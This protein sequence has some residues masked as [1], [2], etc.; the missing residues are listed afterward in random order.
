MIRNYPALQ[1]EIRSAVLPNGL[2]VYYIPKPDF[3]KTFAM[4]AADFG[5]VDCCFTLDGEQH[6]VT[7][8]VAHFLEHKMFEEEDGNALQKFTM[9]GAQPNA[10][11]SHTMT[12]YHFTATERFEECLEILLRFVTTPYFT[13]EN[14]AKE[15]GIIGQEISMLDDTPSWQAYVGVLQGLYGAHTVRISIAGSKQTIAPIT[16]DLLHLCH[17]AFYSPANLVLVVCGTCDFDRVCEMAECITPKQSARIA[18]RSYGEET[19]E[20]AQPMQVRRMAVSRPTFILGIKDTVPSDSYRRQLMGELAARCVC[21]ESA[22][23]YETLYQN[24]LIDQSFDPDY[25][26]FPEG[27]CAMFSGESRDPEAVR[28]ALMEEIRSIAANGVDRALFERARRQL[29]GL[30]LRS[31]DD[32]GSICRMQAEACFAG[33]SCF[34]FYEIL[35][36]VTPE[37]IEARIREWAEPDRS[38]LMVIAPAE[39]E[40]AHG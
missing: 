40:G 35:T 17:R 32:P 39:T 25:F 19:P 21:C 2:R 26:T 33:A 13:D 7:P 8:G 23:L 34:D 36:S 29:L 18:S 15:K 31:A 10:F 20:A 37:E 3:Q 24:N 14:V 1:E 16:P 11:T 9:L 6:Q 4:L 22:P 12:A 28:D 5:S 38:S 27:A 30:K